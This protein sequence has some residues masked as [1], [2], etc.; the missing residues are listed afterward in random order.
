MNEIVSNTE[1]SE[2]LTEEQLTEMNLFARYLK[3]KTFF[4][5]SLILELSHRIVINT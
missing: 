4:K 3:L 2:Q 1:E 5:T